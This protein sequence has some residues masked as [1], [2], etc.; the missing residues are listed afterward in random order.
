MDSVYKPTFSVWEEGRDNYFAEKVQGKMKL[1][2]LKHKE[3]YHAEF[4]IKHKNTEN[5]AVSSGN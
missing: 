2:K 5:I 3:F 1:K 4:Y